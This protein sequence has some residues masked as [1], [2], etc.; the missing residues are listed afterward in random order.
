[1]AKDDGIHEERACRPGPNLRRCC[2]EGRESLT[3]FVRD[4]PLGRL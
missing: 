3:N 4:W 1:M 2:V